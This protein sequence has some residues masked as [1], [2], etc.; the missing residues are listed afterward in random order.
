MRVKRKPY[1]WFHQPMLLY[2]TE[3]LNGYVLSFVFLA[4][5]LLSPFNREVWACHPCF[6]TPDSDKA[7]SARELRTIQNVR[8]KL[9]ISM[10]IRNELCTIE[11][12]WCDIIFTFGKQNYFFES[13]TRYTPRK[14]WHYILFFSK[15]SCNLNL[16][17]VKCP[18]KPNMSQIRQCS[19]LC[20]IIFT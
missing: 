14:N 4:A 18:I 1:S 15:L 20:N 5:C 9:A 7:H 6:C 12:L 10:R 11:G 16:L 13:V 2:V 17:K 8:Q 3:N 19:V